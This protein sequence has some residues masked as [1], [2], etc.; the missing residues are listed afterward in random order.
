MG[1]FLSY[2]MKVETRATCLHY[3]SGCT[4]FQMDVLCLLPLDFFYLKVGVNPLLRLPRCLKVRFQGHGPQLVL[5][6][7]L[8]AACSSGATPR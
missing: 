2:S 7:D 5:L 4:G 1:G 3:I 6:W 8:T